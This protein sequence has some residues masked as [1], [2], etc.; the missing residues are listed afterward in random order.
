M[1]NTI[2][3]DALE[4]IDLLDSD[5]ISRLDIE[6]SAI[7][8]KKIKEES[9]MLSTDAKQLTQFQYAFVQEI[10]GVNCSQRYRMIKSEPGTLRIRFESRSYHANERDIVIASI[11]PDDSI[12]GRKQH[13]YRKT[14]FTDREQAI[15]FFKKVR[16]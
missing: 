11:R 15:K 10:K 1:T 6:I 9:D 13:G 14:Q 4:L 2:F 5:E 7:R 8:K 16:K 12:S 3:Q